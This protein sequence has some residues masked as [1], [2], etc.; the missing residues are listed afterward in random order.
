VS[1][2]WKAT[3]WPMATESR[4]DSKKKLYE[5]AVASRQS[6]QEGRSRLSSMTVYVSEDKGPWQTY[7]RLDFAREAR[8]E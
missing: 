6:Y 2:R 7:E 4:F 8:A 5:F 1:K 3:F